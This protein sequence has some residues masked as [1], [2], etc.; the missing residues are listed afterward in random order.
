MGNGVEALLRR[1]LTSLYGFLHE[2]EALAAGTLGK[3]KEGFK[4]VFG[5]S[6]VQ[7]DE[8]IGPSQ[9]GLSQA[10]I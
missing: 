4:V 1:R 6:Y 7:P 3:S 9:F 5:A 2:R 8:N 10:R